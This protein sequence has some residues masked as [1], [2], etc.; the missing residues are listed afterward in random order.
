V[1]ASIADFFSRSEY[2][3]DILA[4]GPDL[5]EVSAGR[6]LAYLEN[7]IDVLS[8]LEPCREPPFASIGPP[9]FE[10]LAQI[11]TVVAV[12]QDWDAPRRDFLRGLRAQGAAVRAVVVRDGA[13][14]LPW[15]GA[16]AELL[17]VER[18][19][20]ADVERALAS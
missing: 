14:S 5:Y 1:V 6:S 18:M 11:T 2:V 16:A 13:T 4:A 12:L 10:K 15:E 8:C 20:P 19:T 7:I 17:D 3:V 9:L